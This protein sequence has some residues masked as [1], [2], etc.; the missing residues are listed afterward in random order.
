MDVAIFKDWIPEKAD[1]N[2]EMGTQGVKLE[3]L[4]KKLEVYPIFATGEKENLVSLKYRYSLRDGEQWDLRLENFILKDQIFTKEV[5]KVCGEELF[6][7]AFDVDKGTLV[8]KRSQNVGGKSE[9]Y[10]WKIAQIPSYYRT[11]P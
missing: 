8:I 1:W 4:N 2:E 6:S 10:T 5:E 9:T 11:R 3:Y 7:Y